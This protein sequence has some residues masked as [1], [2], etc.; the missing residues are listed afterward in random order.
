MKGLNS[1]LG[2]GKYANKTV[3]E[4]IS[5]GNA[6]Y[7]VWAIKDIAWFELDEM[8]LDA[9]NNKGN[10]SRT[11]FSNR[12]QHNIVSNMVDILGVALYRDAKAKL[13]I[14]RMERFN[15]L[16]VLEADLL[17]DELRSHLTNDS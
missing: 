6:K 16:T 15:R 13:G 14:G 10:H 2:F 4:V 17:I 7:L 12:D 1:C 3:K 8:A 5:S 9:V 11:P